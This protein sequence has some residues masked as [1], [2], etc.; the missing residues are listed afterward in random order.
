MLP[1]RRLVWLFDVDGTLLLTDGAAREAFAAAV[2]EHLGVEDDLEDI[3]FAGRTDPLILADILA[4]HGREFADGAGGRFWETAYGHM[5]T[6]LIP[7][8]GRLLPGVPELLEAVAGE[9]QWVSAL[10]TGNTTGMAR[11]K[12]DHFGIAGRFA[13][14]AFGEEAADRN[15]LA[16]VAVARARER[17]GVPPERCIVVGDTEHDVACARAAGARVVAVAT[18]QRDRATLTGH[19]PDLLLDDL[20][21][22]GPCIAWARALAG[23]A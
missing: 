22:I 7:G 20:A 12:L 6:L 4:K 2:R 21:D 5:R 19:A 9:P 1:A 16:R 8:R 13:F 17:Y 14:G 11:I 3:A 15:A 23:R 18:G 10:L